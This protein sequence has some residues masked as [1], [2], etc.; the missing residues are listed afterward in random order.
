MKITIEGASPAFEE[1]LLRLLD[2]H[3]HE[4]AI[5]ADTDW[6]EDRAEWFLRSVTLAARTFVRRVVDGGGWADAGD[7][8]DEFGSLRGPTVALARG[9][10]RGVRQ[11]R[12]P[13]GTEAPVAVVYDPDNPSWQRAVGYQMPTEHLLV[14]QAAFTRL[15]EATG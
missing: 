2:E 11:G 14:F 15:D 10:Q 12:W 7:L 4:L 5:T 13:Q 3:R 6:S 1:K 8:R 9:L